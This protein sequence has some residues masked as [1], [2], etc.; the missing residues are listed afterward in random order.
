[1]YLVTILNALFEIQNVTWIKRSNPISK[2]AG[3]HFYYN[4]EQFISFPLF[5]K[6]NTCELQNCFQYREA[7]LTINE[8]SDNLN[9]VQNSIQSTSSLE[10]LFW[11]QDL[12]V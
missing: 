8:L 5:Q 2:G 11:S 6:D 9:K 1:M 3:V 4:S 10:N 7:V 12:L